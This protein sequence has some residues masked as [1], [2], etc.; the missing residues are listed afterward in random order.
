MNVREYLS[1]RRACALVRQ[2]VPSSKR[3]TFEEMAILCHLANADRALQ[4]SQIAEYQG[5][6]RPTMT[7]RTNHLAQLGLIEREKGQVDHRNVLC[8]ISERGREKLEHG[9]TL[10]CDNIT[11][12]MPLS[13][14]APSR[15]QQIVDALGSVSISSSDL[16]LLV[17]SIFDEQGGLSIS[18]I[19]EKLGL[20]QPTVSMAVA[21]L[22][23]SGDVERSTEQ[24]SIRG[25]Q[26]RLSVQGRQRAE[27]LSSQLESLHVRTP[28]RQAVSQ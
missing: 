10:L 5:V 6:L 1:V 28:R 4:I 9:I 17:L 7:H 26:V 16:V 8:K 2:T 27:K 24:G 25:S 21:L 15:M 12:G 18:E 3:F 13:R 11:T 14:C 22:T 23:E 19:V 20:L